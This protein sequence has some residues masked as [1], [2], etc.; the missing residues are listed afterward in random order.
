[1]PRNKRRRTGC[2][3]CRERRVKCD[4][5]KPSCERCETANIACA[6]YPQMR[7][8][9]P[10]PR[11]L[12]QEPLSTD[13]QRPEPGQ[14]YSCWPV[15]LPNSPRPDQSP[16]LGARHV[17][18]YHYFLSRTL[19]LLFPHEHVYFWRDVLCQEAWGSD[20]VHLT[21][22]TLGNLHR[23]VIIMAARDENIQQNG[24]YEKLSAV[25]Q[26]T[27][28]LQELANHLDDAKLIPEVLIGILCLMAYFEVS[29]QVAMSRIQSRDS[30]D[31]VSVVQ[32]QS[33]CLCRAFESRRPLFADPY[34][35]ARYHIC[36]VC[37]RSTY[38]A[39]RLFAVTESDMSYRSAISSALGDSIRLSFLQSSCTACAYASGADSRCTTRTA[40]NDSHG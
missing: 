17:L 9:G 18:G 11:R 21:L 31:C 14:I 39:G 1:M 15:T 19:P 7:H 13:M 4:E 25:Q 8:V 5:R 34:L 23:A 16:G 10:E 20:Y 37:K 38:P 36:W 27:Q 12:R 30:P 22:T 33:T 28:A 6:G 24:I 35:V 29:L 40:D 3:S 2:L 26:Y 32:R